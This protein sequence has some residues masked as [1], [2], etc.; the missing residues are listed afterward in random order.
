MSKKKKKSHS[1]QVKETVN[2]STVSYIMELLGWVIVSIGFC[3]NYE[4]ITEI[5][6]QHRQFSTILGNGLSPSIKTSFFI[7]YLLSS[8]SLAGRSFHVT[9]FTLRGS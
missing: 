4:E 7:S 1:D 6:H 9:Y 2:I 3:C 5:L 8:C